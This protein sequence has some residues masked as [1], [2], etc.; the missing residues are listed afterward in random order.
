MVWFLLRKA[1]T[2]LVLPP[3][4]PLI[5]AILGLAALRRWPRLGRALASLGILT[6]LALSLPVVSDVL[7]RSLDQSPPLN[8]GQVGDAGA[9][10]ILGGGIRRDAAE[11]GGDTLGR[12]SLER[13][14]YG[15]LVARKTGLPVLVSGGPV[16]G[17]TPEATVMKR[18]LE[19]EYGI[20]VRWAEVTS[21]N[22]HENALRSAEI[23]L[24]E[25]IHHVILVAH[26]FDMPRA[27]A[28][29]AAAGLEATLAPT[30]IP[31]GSFYLGDLL[32]SVG[33]LQQS[34]YA[35]Y[36][37]LANAVRAVGLR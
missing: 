26:S 20:T 11:Y 8:F 4:G 29:L 30:A 18:A 35:L 25:N 13:V 22:T 34:Y 23:L 21:R 31:H 24:A 3:T 1:L 2:A 32:P 37:L 12:L 16:F 17:S 9:I 15:A 33:A 7:V 36:E 14:R 27:K 19:D 10:V 5:V 28:E 6:L